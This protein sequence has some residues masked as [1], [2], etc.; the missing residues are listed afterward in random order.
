MGRSGVDIYPLQSGLGLE[1]VE[2][3]G[4]F[5]GGSP[6]NVAVAAA[7]MGHTAAVITGVGDDPFGKFVRKEMCRLGVSDQFVITTKN[8]KTPVTFCEIFPQIHSRFI[9]IE[10]LLLQIF[11]CVLVTFLLM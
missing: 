10:S 11:N 4:K 1:D 2:T 9:F 3:F 5:L 8:Y 6:T 7:R